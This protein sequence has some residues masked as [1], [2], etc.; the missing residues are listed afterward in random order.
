MRVEGSVAL[1]T[2]A[3]RG[4]GAVF[5]RTLLERGATRVYAAARNP[6][7]VAA[8]PGVVPLRLDVTHPDEVSAAAAACQDVT[9]V[10]N[11]AGLATGATA[12]GERALED[13][14]REMET[15]VFGLLAVSRAFAPVLATNGGGALV[16]VLSV[17]SWV[18]FPS[19]PLYAA[20]KAAAWSLTNGLRLALKPQGTLV[21]GVHCGFIDTDMS[22]GIEA[23]K[24]S[25]EVVVA[26]TLEALEAGHNE[27]LVD[28]LSRTVRA[29]LSGD[30]ANLYPAL[31]A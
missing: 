15:N 18:T 6:S 9:L 8:M 10:V 24:T 23:P 12:L 26:R 2:G 13:G 19:A 28:D 22:A 20:T 29:A 16:N 25:P 5:T 11:N 17:L 31:A 4:L 21:V 1:V 14:R 27:V 7:A 3:S 30:L